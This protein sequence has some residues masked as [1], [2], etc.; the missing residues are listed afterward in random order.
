MLE[1]PIRAR[2]DSRLLAKSR[3]YTVASPPS[4]SS[5]RIRLALV[6]IRS[7]PEYP[8]PQSP[9]RATGPV[10]IAGGSQASHE[11]DS[12]ARALLFAVFALL[13]AQWVPVDRDNPPVLGEIE[14]PP[15]VHAILERSCYDCHSNQTRWPWYSRMAP[16]SWL[17][18]SDV[19]EGRE[20]LNF[21]AWRSDSTDKRHELREEIR[22]NVEEG[23]M[24][25]WF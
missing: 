3:Q 6:G 11:G 5:A 20:H 19:H 13:A 10:R 1:D 8:A 7:T 25:L 22:K 2:A 15:E 12:D 21:S 18:A 16:V 9:P 4:P 23:E 14:S 17:V 24:P